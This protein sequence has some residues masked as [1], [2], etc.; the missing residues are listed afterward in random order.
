[1]VWK[2][3]RQVFMFVPLDNRPQHLSHSELQNRMFR[4]NVWR[5]DGCKLGFTALQLHFI[6]IFTLSSSILH[7]G[8]VTVFS[9]HQLATHWDM[10][11]WFTLN[12]VFWAAPSWSSRMMQTHLDQHPLDGASCQS[13]NIH[14]RC[15]RCLSVCFTLNGTITKT[16][17]A[18]FI[19]QD[20][21]LGI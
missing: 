10:T 19:K 12:F 17:T 1:M 4:A 14:S 8:I 18:Y 16:F 13:H 7:W 9:L 20:L 11:H 3:I 21:K 6:N 2:I 15:P 5:D